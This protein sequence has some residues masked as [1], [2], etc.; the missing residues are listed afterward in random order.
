MSC[1]LLLSCYH[2]GQQVARS[3]CSCPVLLL[4]IALVTCCAVPYI[5]RQPFLH[6]S[7][8]QAYS[9]ACT[10]EFYVLHPDH[11]LAY[12]GQFDASRPKAGS[13]PVTG[14][15]CMDPFRCLHPSCIQ[16]TG[17]ISLV[18]N[19]ILYN[20]QACMIMFGVGG[21]IL[22]THYTSE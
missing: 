2:E 3:D 10:P 17:Y 22:S 14:S 12:H 11:T 6:A 15:K 19:S 21:S 13:A 9:A 5:H 1:I 7:H 20:S 18:L 16:T 8:L 4:Q